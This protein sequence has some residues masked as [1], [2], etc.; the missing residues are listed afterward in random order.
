MWEARSR[1]F[2]GVQFRGPGEM[3]GGRARRAIAGSGARPGAGPGGNFK[4]FLKLYL[5]SPLPGARSAPG[6]PPKAAPGGDFTGVSV[7]S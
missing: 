6:A 1:G 4:D 7:K 3:A 2:L 5:S